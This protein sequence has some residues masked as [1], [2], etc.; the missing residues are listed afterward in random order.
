MSG[1]NFRISKPENKLAIGSSRLFG[2]PDVWDGFEW[3]CIEEN[4]EKYDLTFMGQINCIEAA[5][6]NDDS[7][8]PEM[9]MLYFF[10]DLDTMPEMPHDK[11]A[12]VIWYNGG[13]SGLHEMML[14]DEDGN[15]MAFPELKIDFEAAGADK[16][17]FC[18]LPGDSIPDSTGNYDSIMDWTALL[19]LVSFE[20][21]DVEIRFKDGG[22]LCF[23]IE[24]NNLS[25]YDFS[26]VRTAQIKF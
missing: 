4:G 12:R 26:D 6:F 13:M 14:T 20:T 15:N 9:G 10:Y 3:P 1:I 19:Q 21:E 24:Y 25:A 17:T 23:Y 8:L 22:M 2:N 5:V 11:S 7:P 16:S 18:L